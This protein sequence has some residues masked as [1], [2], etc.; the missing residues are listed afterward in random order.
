MTRTQRLALC[1]TA[2]LLIAVRAGALPDSIQNVQ[3]S[4]WWVARWDNS[5]VFWLANE[6]STL[7]HTSLI[8]VGQPGPWT[9][10]RAWF[11][12]GE[13]YHAGLVSDSLVALAQARAR[14]LAS[15]NSYDYPRDSK[16]YLAPR[17]AP[18]TLQRAAAALAGV[19]NAR[20]REIDRLNAESRR[21]DRRGENTTTGMLQSQTVT[22]ATRQCAYQAAGALHIQTLPATSLCPQTLEV[23]WP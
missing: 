6:D 11:D 18:S 22:G 23:P 14:Y 21:E 20:A 12:R 4:I 3:D 5:T 8:P 17:S 13:A 15:L 16:S 19:A 2:G 10:W 7:F 1:L 9:S